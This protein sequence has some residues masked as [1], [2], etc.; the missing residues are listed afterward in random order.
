MEL[1]GGS[2]LGSWTTCGLAGRQLWLLVSCVSCAVHSSP[3][4]ICPLGDRSD[5]CVVFEI[6][7]RLPSCRMHQGATPPA[8]LRG[9]NSR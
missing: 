2:A 1:E 5:Q 9:T 8:S 6:Y 7:G 4:M 3:N